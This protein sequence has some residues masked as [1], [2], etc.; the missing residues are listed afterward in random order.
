MDRAMAMT[1]HAR[2]SYRDLGAGR[3]PRHTIAL[4]ILLPIVLSRLPDGLA[5][6]S[7]VALGC[8]GHLVLKVLPE[9][10]TLALGEPGLVLAPVRVQGQAAARMHVLRQASPHSIG[11]PVD[12]RLDHKLASCPA[13]SRKMIFPLESKPSTLPSRIPPPQLQETESWL[14]DSTADG[15]SIQMRRTGLRQSRPC[16]YP[17]KNK[18]RGRCSSRN[19]AI[20]SGS[21]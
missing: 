15:I 1:Q 20:R 16:G 12:S 6:G 13:W 17:G 11:L 10:I 4:G 7:H 2:R 14:S 3:T 5:L 18:E 8:A 19:A 9:P 21:P